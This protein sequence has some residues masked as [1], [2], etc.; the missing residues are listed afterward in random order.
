MREKK[1]TFLSKLNE[2]IE[3][4]SNKKLINSLMVFLLVLIPILLSIYLR[5]QPYYLPATDD[6]ATN[7]IERQVKASISQAIAEKY[8][9][10][11][12]F[13]RNKLIEQ[14]YSLY[15]SKNKNFLESQ[16]QLLSQNFKDQLRSDEENVTYLIAIDPY[17][18]YRVARNEIKLGYPGDIKIDNKTSVDYLMFG[19]A[20]IENKPKY[21]GSFTN[22]LDF[23]ESRSYKVL[24]ALGFKPSLMKVAFFM[25]LILMTL[26]V[27]PA[28][29][30][31]KR[32]SGNIGGFFTAV[33][34]AIHPFVLRRTAAGFSDTDAF[35]ILFPI[36][37]AWFFLET[38]K[39]S[40]LKRGIIFS[41]LTAFSIWLY[42]IAWGGFGSML[43]ILLG[44]IGLYLG[45][46]LSK[47][48]FV[49]KDKNKKEV[50]DRIKTELIFVGVLLLSTWLLLSFRPG[51]MINFSYLF[52]VVKN[53]LGFTQIK[54]VATTKIWPNVY[55]TVAELNPGSLNDVINSSGGKI[56]FWFSIIGVALAF[57]TKDK[58]G[59]WN[60]AFGILL[61]LWYAATLYAV[62][63]GIR[64]VLLVAPVFAVS[65][66]LF[67]GR[68]I[69][70][71]SNYFDKWFEIKKNTSRI[72]LIVLFAMIVFV[73]QNS[74]F[75]Q[76]KAVA[77]SEFPSMN[78]GWYNALTAIRDNS[79]KDAIITSWWDFGHWFK[80]IAQRQVTFDGASQNTPMAH[81]V[82]RSLLTDN[83]TEALTILRM[84]D[85]GS[86]YAYDLI[87]EKLNDS[88]ASVKLVKKIIS[89]PKSKAKQELLKNFSEQE[90]NEIL[91]YTHCTPPEAFY[92][93]S[94]DM[95]GKAGVWAH[96]G[97]WDFEK[98]AMY[99]EVK[100]KPYKVAKD[101]LMNK[102]NLSPEDAERYYNEILT[103]KNADYWVSP[104]P[105]YQGSETS[106]KQNNETLDCI[107]LFS[108]NQG[109][110]VL[111][112]LSN[113]EAYINEFKEQN[114]PAEFVYFK[115]NEPVVKKYNN[116]V[117]KLG[118]ALK[119][120]SNKYSVII[121]DPLLT[122]SLF[123][124]LFFFEGK[125]TKYFDLFKETTTVFGERIYVWKVNWDKFLS[126]FEG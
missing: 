43:V 105:A 13:E 41:I 63:K 113:M 19:G 29:F 99:K 101:I 64:F 52:T 125:G 86:N 3:G 45:Y 117:V 11:P 51:S 82:G 55:T 5:I 81:W 16:A 84:L 90:A 100:G 114:R 111:I 53:T 79:S 49:K 61:L 4:K 42:S 39:S 57:L 119:N 62:S 23:L 88:Y 12:D 15:V 33:I 66:G 92:I 59:K 9:L 44:S 107:K 54:A 40:N 76:A 30:L 25:P 36:T 103:T 17:H 65:L 91:N 78:D 123:S 6:W 85:C 47:A 89:L 2:A 108:Q 10:L 69:E 70:V 120:E 121:S 56:V 67:I 26:A 106:C 28:F 115:D 32:L 104:W 46:L 8:P 31:G 7:A 14:Q 109:I 24:H 75:A 34:V 95:V 71:V 22:L 37:I 102:F 94:E 50:I 96:F 35:N 74:L 21:T 112:N 68:T 124:R 83:E 73:G 98:A 72:L 122:N 110:R 60:P 116:P 18:Y 87:N 80:A 58:N 48:I 1:P 77:Y 38:I 97:S 118:I 126:D 20:P 27:I 93:T